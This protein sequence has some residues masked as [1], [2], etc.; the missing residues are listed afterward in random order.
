M[1]NLDRFEIGSNFNRIGSD[2][3]GVEGGRSLFFL[4]GKSV[5]FIVG[6]SLFDF[7]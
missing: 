4:V 1:G 3:E 2:C 6:N 5:S 7:D